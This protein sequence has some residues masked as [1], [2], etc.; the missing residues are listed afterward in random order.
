M[1]LRHVLE[2]RCA[3]CRVPRQHGLAESDP[4]AYPLIDRTPRETMLSVRDLCLER[5]FQPVFEPLSFKL[6]GGELLVVTGPNGSGKTT[7]VR[8]LAGLIDPTSGSIE[9]HPHRMHYV[10]HEAAVK[11]ELSVWENLAFYARLSRNTDGA[12]EAVRRLGLKDCAEQVGR[13]LSAGQR[14]RTALARL[15]LSRSDLWLLDEP[16]TNLDAAGIALVDSLLDAHLSSGGACVMATHGDHR[17]TPP[18]G[19]WRASEIALQVAAQAD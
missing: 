11:A 18:S 14:K 13:T 5:H 15:V 16:Y 8:L 1:Y 3:P 7:L 6:S 2:A 17:P 10:G 12:E 19:P 9:K 4:V